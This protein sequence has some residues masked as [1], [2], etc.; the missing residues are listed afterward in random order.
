M[1]ILLLIIVVLLA[2]ILFSVWYNTH[3]LRV[4]IDDQNKKK[5]LPPL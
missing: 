2:L 5:I 4:M 1:E 3:L